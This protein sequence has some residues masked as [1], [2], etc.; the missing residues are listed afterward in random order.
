[1]IDIDYKVLV[2]GYNYLIHYKL[3]KEVDISVYKKIIDEGL[4]KEETDII[5]NSGNSSITDSNK[6]ISYTSEEL[7]IESDQIVNIIIYIS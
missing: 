5:N 7:N 1:M 3:V 4:Y 6:S 2:K